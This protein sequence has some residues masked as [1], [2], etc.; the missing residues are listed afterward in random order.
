MKPQRRWHKI[1]YFFLLLLSLNRGHTGFA[2][3]TDSADVHVI[4]EPN[5][6]SHATTL[7]VIPKRFW[8]VT[9]LHAVGYGGSLAA[10]AGVWYS[11][12]DKTKLHAFNDLDEWGGMDKVGHANTAWQLANFS[13]SLYRY[14]GLSQKKSALVG[15]GF[16]MLY[17]TTLEFF[18][19][20]SA[21]W[22]FSF[23]DM[24]ANLAGSTLAYFRNIGKLHNLQ[25]KYSW[26]YTRYP[27][28]RQE[29]L[30]KTTP[31]RM[32][33]D[34]NGQTY[35]LSINIPKAWFREHKNWLCFSLGYSIDGFT[36]GSQNYFDARI[37]NPPAF[38]RVG[39]FF[40]SLDLDVSKFKVK[41]KFLRTVLKAVNLVKVPAPAIGI[42]TNGKL[43]LKPFYF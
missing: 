28:Y 4:D 15:S 18:D 20:Y 5:I 41:D 43:L 26:H 39:E 1:P 11:D 14:T 13:Y 6:E 24:G 31:E 19:G 12:F 30:G 32:L 17:L 3:S 16:A 25:F 2:Q 29:V 10:L 21:K 35:W 9:A 7:K 22:G 8:P 40:L 23:P 34:Y 33:K 37:A 42:T 27:L 38:D 36:G